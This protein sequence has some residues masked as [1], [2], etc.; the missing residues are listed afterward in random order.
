MPPGISLADFY[1]I[2][3]ELVITGGAL[4]VLIADVLLP[5]ERRTAPTRV[6]DCAPAGRHECE[7]QPDG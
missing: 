3:P 4:I 5:R 6:D 7:D 2:L 1:Y